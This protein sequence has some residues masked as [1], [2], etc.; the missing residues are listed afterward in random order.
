MRDVRLILYRAKRKGVLYDR[1]GS[2]CGLQIR[3]KITQRPSK[4]PC[5]EQKAVIAAFSLGLKL[6]ITHESHIEPLALG[7]T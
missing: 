7:A 4:G 3:S 1:G 5:L 6:L 2:V